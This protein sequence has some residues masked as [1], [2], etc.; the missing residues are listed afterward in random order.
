VC[1]GGTASGGS[2]WPLWA[3]AL[4]S[5]TC[6]HVV[7]Q[8]HLDPFQRG[9]PTAPL[10]HQKCPRF[11]C[12]AHQA[13]VH[14]R[15]SCL[16]RMPLTD[17][18]GGTFARSKTVLQWVLVPK[19]GKLSPYAM[20]WQLTTNGVTKMELTLQKN[21]MINRTNQTFANVNE[22]GFPLCGIQT[23]LS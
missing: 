20:L 13:P 12:P 7:L 19:G 15:G 9:A 10:A 22:R 18:L 8:H 1:A 11:C 2:G 3:A 16:G 21:E 4:L 5:H 17:G 14:C 6:Q 23:R